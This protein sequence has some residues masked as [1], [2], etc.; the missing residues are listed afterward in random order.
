MGFRCRFFFRIDDFSCIFLSIFTGKRRSSVE[1]LYNLEKTPIDIG[2]VAQTETFFTSCLR[3][4]NIDVVCDIG[5]MDGTHSQI[6][7][8]NISK[9]GKI[10]IFEANPKNHENIR[11]NPAFDKSYF[12]IENIAVSDRN[13]PIEFNV[14]EV[15]EKNPKANRGCSSLLRRSNVFLESQFAHSEKT[16]SVEVSSRR[17]DDFIKENCSNYKK[18]NIALWIDVEGAAKLVLD[19]SIEILDRVVMI[20]VE[21]ERRIEWEGQKKYE[22]IVNLL[23]R[24]NFVAWKHNFFDDSVSQGDILFIRK[25]V[26]E[27]LGNSVYKAK[28]FY[29]FKKVISVLARKSFNL[30]PFSQRIKLKYKLRMPLFLR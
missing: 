2:Q 7:S 30:I 19:G 10:F 17:I 28:T 25:D 20:H 8:K 5:A 13:G 6:F 12:S 26:L 24:Y 21:V 16:M 23:K 22:D 9:K 27:Q 29:F 18:Q 1:K 4:F 14:V 11:R 15:D 3:A